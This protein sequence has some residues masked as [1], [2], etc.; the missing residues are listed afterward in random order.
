MNRFYSCLLIII[1]N[2]CTYSAEYFTYDKIDSTLHAWQDKF[3]F[4]EHNIYGQEFGTIYQLDT[5]GYSTNNNLPIFAV[6]LSDNA[7]I[8]EDET[9]VLILGQCHAEEIYGVE[10]AMAII[11]CYLDPEDC[12]KYDK[13]QDYG[14]TSGDLNEYLFNFLEKL[15]VWIIPTHNPDGLKV[16]HGYCNDGNNKSESSCIASNS[17]WIEDPS[18]R[19]NTRDVNL[20]GKFISPDDWIPVVG[21][22][23]DGVDLNRNY[24]LN[25]IFGHDKF[26]YTYGTEYASCN[27]YYQDDFDYYKGGIPFSESETT[28]IKT[29]A[30][31]NY[32][33]SIAYHSSRSGCVAERVVFPWGW[34][35]S[36]LPRKLSPDFP[37]IRTLG[38]I[39]HTDILG[40]SDDAEGIFQARPQGSRYGNAHDWLYRETGC[41][42]YLIEVG[43]FDYGVDGLTDNELLIDNNYDEILDRNFEVLFYLFNIAAGETNIVSSS[44]KKLSQITGT[45]TD[46]SN[47]IID[48]VNVKILEMDGL[49]LKP[50]ITDKF[51]RYRRLLNS[52][53]LYTLVVSAPG[54]ITDTTV[55][56][57]LIEG[58][59]EYNF[60]LE[61]QPIYKLKIS[62]HTPEDYVGNIKIIK[63]NSFYADTIMISDSILWS[64][65][66]DNYKIIIL[67][68]DLS[69]VVLE[70][71]LNE[72]REY[73]V[74]LDF[75][76][77]LFNESFNYLSQ[78]DIISGEWS[79]HGDTLRSQS[80]FF[81]DNNA[82]WEI[83]TN[84]GI[85]VVSNDS[86]IIE[87]SLRYELEWE[88]DHY[89]MIYVTE[90]GMDT[91]LDL[92]G[93]EYEFITQYVPLVIP[94]GQSGGNLQLSL[95]SDYNL[96]YRGVEM[97][98]IVIYN[99]GQYNSNTLS[100]PSLILPDHFTLQQN[101]PNPFNPRTSINF[102][103]PYISSIS[104]SVFDIQ[105]KFIEKLVD[106]LYEPGNYAT[107]L[108]ADD[109]SSGI[110]FY[111]L[112]TDHSFITRKFI[113]IK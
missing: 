67:A 111:R 68:N 18:Y 47:N 72:P 1:L 64:L 81:Y 34:K 95:Q 87:I 36:E 106:D 69:P 59:N 37:V 42:Q 102:S 99:S 82:D 32:F 44:Q 112:Q 50:R 98:R 26:Q 79:I 73:S 57:N 83:I 6:K 48:S 52:D 13:N 21:Q 31:N 4:N 91:L 88:K 108:D 30:E 38:D 113:I 9:R 24:D 8:D 71:P 70:I 93:G 104:I 110:Y 20:N 109:Y 100:S 2:C 90:N 29:L 33:L 19:K 17:I 28:A 86:L 62:V 105:G 80:G 56:N 15:E 63:K 66:K 51:G 49:V 41:I 16:V 60:Q 78:W 107:Y 75:D 3:G 22:D 77:S 46:G 89:Y 94:Q 43:N 27:S 23:M 7:D 84:T 96:N 45:V 5:I 101:Y 54:Y 39:L 65:S 12:S 55:F 53:S 58:I 92:T 40:F 76:E 10:I 14:F 103:V 11:D 97:D 35:D 61:S 74:N 25:W 85:D